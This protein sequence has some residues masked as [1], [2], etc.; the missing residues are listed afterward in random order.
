ML[1]THDKWLLPKAAPELPEM[2]GE[3]Q[4]R[5]LLDILWK[6][7]RSYALNVPEQAWRS[8]M[9]ET[10]LANDAVFEAL[11]KEYELEIS[12]R[13]HEDHSDPLDDGDEAYERSRDR[14]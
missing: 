7:F 12:T 8:W 13:W 9:D 14:D 5:I 6:D 3:D 2:D 1:S 4:V 11:L 10:I